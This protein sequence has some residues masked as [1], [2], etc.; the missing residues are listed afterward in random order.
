M[1]YINKTTNKII[2]AGTAIT[3]GSYTYINPTE[4]KYAELGWQPYTPAEE[5]VDIE[6]VK[7][8][9]I[10][11]LMEYDNS[12]A[13]NSFTFNGKQYWLDKTTRMGLVNLLNST[14]GVGEEFL[15]IG[16]G[17]DWFL[18]PCEKALKM[19]QTLEVYAGKCWNRTQKH[20]IA[21]M[22][23]ET[24]EEVQEYDFK[25]GYPEPPTYII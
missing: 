24:L 10:S 8:D 19:F 21:I 5:P 13:V 11:D 25:E 7:A 1:L 18:V 14:L 17:E 12:T 15:E 3:D 16:M 4:E 9:K 2:S 20:L 22:A 6:R 23:L